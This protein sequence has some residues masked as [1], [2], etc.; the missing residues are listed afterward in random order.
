MSDK[1]E[2]AIVEWLWMSTASAFTCP[3]AVIRPKKAVMLKL[4]AFS[5]P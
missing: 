4:S 1:L 2:Y 5:R 3:M